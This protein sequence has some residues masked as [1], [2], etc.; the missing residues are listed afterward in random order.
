MDDRREQ[1]RIAQEKWRKNRVSKNNKNKPRSAEVSHCHAQ[2]AHAD[3]DADAD[4]HVH[5]SEEKVCT[6]GKGN[7]PSASPKAPTLP[8]ELFFEEIKRHYPDIDIDRELGKMRAIHFSHQKQ[9]PADDSS[10]YGRVAKSLRRS[11]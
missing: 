3:A 9:R 8:D 6:G 7:Q 10:L 2:S 5:A 11:N 4:V 1:N